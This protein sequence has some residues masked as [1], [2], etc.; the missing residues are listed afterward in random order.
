MLAGCSAHRY[1]GV[2]LRARAASP[3]LR[4]LT[5]RARFRDRRAQRELGIRFEEA[6]GVSA[7]IARAKYLY[8][9]VVAER[10]GVLWVYTPSVVQGQPGRVAPLDLGPKSPGLDEARRRLASLDYAKRQINKIPKINR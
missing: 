8:R 2:P 4:A 6:R 5:T 3:E 7:S 1:A 9:K 10:G